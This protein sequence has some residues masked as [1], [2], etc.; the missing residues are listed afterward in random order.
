M[1]DNVKVSENL[2]TDKNIA[3]IV[4]KPEITE[5]TR[6]EKF[7]RIAEYR[8]IKS[9]DMIRL[10][11][12]LTSAQYQSTSDNW[13]MIIGALVQA[14]Q[15]LDNKRRHNKPDEKTFSLKPMKLEQV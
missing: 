1:A 9:L 14:V 15:E 13:D 7:E 3:K 4:Q 11:G 2:V 10:L 12:N 5:E 8:T 6:S